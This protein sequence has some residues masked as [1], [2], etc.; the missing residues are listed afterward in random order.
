MTS[1]TTPPTVA[2]TAGELHTGPGLRARK[3]ARAPWWW[4]SPARVAVLAAVMLV[5]TQCVAAGYEF[6]QGEQVLLSVKGI[7]WADPTAFVN[8]WFNSDAPQPHIL[9]DVITYL[10]ESAGL[11]APAY[12][13]YWLGSLVAVAWALVLLSDRWLPRRARPLELLA[14]A[15]LVTGPYF[16]LGTFLVIH[17]EAVPNALGGALGFLTV[18]LLICQRDRAALVAAAATTAVHV[19]HGTVV[20]GALLVAWLVDGQRFR[21]PIVRWFPVAVIGILAAVYGVGVV[22]GLVSGSGDVVAICETASPGHCDPDSWPRNVILSGL[23]VL[24]L[25]V[26]APLVVRNRSLR[27]TALV[28]APALVAVVALATDLADLEPF[29]TLGRQFFLYR[30]VMA[31]APFAPLAIVALMARATELRHRARNLAFAGVGVVLFVIWHA[32][33]YANLVRFRTTVTGARSATLLLGA[34]LVVGLAL[35]V[36]GGVRYRAVARH[37]R[38]VV[39]FGCVMAVTALL[40]FGSRATGFVPLAVQY[41]PEDGSVALGKRIHELTPTGAVIAARPDI[42]WLRLMS[43]R[44]VIVDCKSVPYGGQ[45]WH[46]YN[47]R[48][49]ALGVPRPLECGA[50]GFS[51]LTPEQLIGLRSRYG[52]TYV[53]LDPSDEAYDYADSHWASP[54]DL[55]G[56]L[57][58]F[59]IQREQS[60]S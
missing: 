14:A 6:G 8:D 36:V 46:E 45:P 35:T 25:G 13:L 4:S 23:F 19:Q 20:A 48:L 55:G 26:A 18:A 11:R 42:A 54:G 37:L 12:F 34:A 49:A 10:A 30:F 21:R 2:V 15:M 44:A 47:E 5:S 27:A 43:R 17:R 57:R 60:G 33:S 9:F 56:P 28:A 1:A 7:G 39:A 29:Q 32:L 53:L 31:V 41:H 24:A 3:R 51:R 40:A 52:A 50:D 22:R 59:K 38:G 16:A 58:L